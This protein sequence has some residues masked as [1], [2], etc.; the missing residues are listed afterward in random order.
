MNNGGAQGSCPLVR[1]LQP[2]SPAILLL[3]DRSAKTSSPDDQGNPWWK[4]ENEAIKAAIASAPSVKF[5]YRPFPLPNQSNCGGGDPWNETWMGM[6]KDKIEGCMSGNCVAQ[7]TEIPLA[8]AL[9]NVYKSDLSLP[10]GWDWNLKP[11]LVVLLGG[12]PSCGANACANV[13]TDLFNLS[14]KSRMSEAIV[15]FG[16]AALDPG[17]C[18][19]SLQSITT[20]GPSSTAKTNEELKSNLT[21]TILRIVAQTQCTFVS[22]LFNPYDHVDKLLVQIGA[23]SANPMELT[24]GGGSWD[25]DGVS[26]EISGMPCQKIS[27]AL[28]KNESVSVSAVLS[29][30]K[31]NM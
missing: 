16:A 23:A 4:G 5:G 26:F 22:G 31:G 30:C 14:T 10:G 29:S 17:T 3:T 15:P 1:P 8:N 24:N 20:Q 21:A 2:Q 9:D 6:V 27:D 12:P 25:G 18:L 13:T 7:L 28:S 11:W 19:A